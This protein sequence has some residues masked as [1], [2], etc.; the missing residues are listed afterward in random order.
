MTFTKVIE[1]KRIET[2]DA[3]LAFVDGQGYAIKE[4]GIVGFDPC[5]LDSFIADCMVPI[6]QGREKMLIELKD[7]EG[8]VSAPFRFSGHSLFMSPNVFGRG[9]TLY[10][11]GAKVVPLS[12][13]QLKLLIRP[14]DLH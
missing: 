10:V 11:N 1:G 13:E 5:K 6:A 3:I 2:L 14:G 7:Q 8:N 9:L 12:V 4:C